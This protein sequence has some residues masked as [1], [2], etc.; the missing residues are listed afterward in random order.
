MAV[1]V[2]GQIV[3]RAAGAFRVENGRLIL[4]PDGAAPFDAN[5]QLQG[6]RITLVLPGFA[7]GVTFAR[8]GNP[9]AG[10]PR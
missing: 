3:D 6:D 8:Q 10:P 5:A 2:G 7:T 1:W 9:G 4:M